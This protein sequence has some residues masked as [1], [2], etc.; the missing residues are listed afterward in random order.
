MRI[1]FIDNVV[2]RHVDH[3]KIID[4]FNKH[5]FILKA[6]CTTDELESS[7][8]NIIIVHKGNTREYNC[9]L[10]NQLGTHR[11]FFSGAE[12]NPRKTEKGIFAST[13]TIEQDLSELL[14]NE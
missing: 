4:R 1:L 10:G 11:I 7:K 14:D 6:N 13:Y 8:Y 12:R 2:E 3:Q 5:K 9:T